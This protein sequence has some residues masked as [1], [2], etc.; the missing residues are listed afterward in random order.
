MLDDDLLVALPAAHP[1]AARRRVPLDGLADEPWIVA[2]EP[3]AVAA[4]HARCEAAGFVPRTP[5][6][7]AEWLSKLGLVAEGFG[8]T[9]VPALAAAR[10][11]GTPSCCAPSRRGARPVRRAGASTPSWGGTPA[12]RP[13]S[14]RSWRTCGTSPPT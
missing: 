6:R 11:R 13:P 10:R 4:L 7:A 14:P 5:L 9:F 2:D 3:A 12:G 1:L 8:V